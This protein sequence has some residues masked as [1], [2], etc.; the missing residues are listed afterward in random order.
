MSTKKA[1]PSRNAAAPSPLIGGLYCHTCGRVITLRKSHAKSL[2]TSTPPKY[3]SDRCRREKPPANQQG[4]EG[5]IERAFVEML[6]WGGRR[7]VDCAEV[8][9]KV[10]G[11][12]AK[13]GELDVREHDALESGEACSSGQTSDDDDDGGVPLDGYPLPGVSSERNREV[14]DNLTPQQLGRQR[15]ANREKVRQAARRGAVFG[16]HTRS[17]EALTQSQSRKDHEGGDIRRKRVEAIQSGRVVEAS[18][19]KG[20]WGVRWK[21]EQG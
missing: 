14:I 16:F 9:R 20:P 12:L 18:F 15:A 3:C 6:G 2:H 1:R 19:A 5:E 8:E 11:A 13:S 21:D 4:V 10:F 17:T 7:V